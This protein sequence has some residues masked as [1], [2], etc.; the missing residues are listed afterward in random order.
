MLKKLKRQ[1]RKIQQEFAP[2]KNDL[3][4]IIASEKDFKEFTESGEWEDLSHQEIQKCYE[5]RRR[6]KTFCVQISFIQ[7]TKRKSYSIFEMKTYTTLSNVTKNQPFAQS[8]PSGKE[9][10]PTLITCQ[11]F[12]Q[13]GMVCQ[14]LKL[15]PGASDNEIAVNTRLSLYKVSSLRT[16]IE[17]NGL[18]N[19]PIQNKTTAIPKVPNP[20][21]ANQKDQVDYRIEKKNNI[22]NSTETSFPTTPTTENATKNQQYAKCDNCASKITIEEYDRHDGLCSECYYHKLSGDFTRDERNAGLLGKDRTY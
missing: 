15:N 13:C 18:L 14:Y 7:A 5:F 19:S 9:N 2:P 21:E 11:D 16:Y 4:I 6:N 8:K 22:V 12:S 10:M 1:K 20:P 3:R 17:H